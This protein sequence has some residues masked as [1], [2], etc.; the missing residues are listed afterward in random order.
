MKYIFGTPCS[1]VKDICG[2]A[3]RVGG[4]G[5]GTTGARGVNGRGGAGEGVV[6]KGRVG[7]GLFGKGGASGGRTGIVVA[8]KG[9][10]WVRRS[11]HRRRCGGVASWKAWQA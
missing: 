4:G 2:V 5:V 8:G 9:W 10:R 3:G 1:S 7:R 6:G 11:R